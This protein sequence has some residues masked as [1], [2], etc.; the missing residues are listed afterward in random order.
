MV[1]KKLYVVRSS[2]L[3]TLGSIIVS[4][5]SKL[6]IMN[7]AYKFVT[8][9]E[10]KILSWTLILTNIILILH[11]KIHVIQQYSLIRTS[12]LYDELKCMQN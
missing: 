6:S 1:K 5:T 9:H 7:T 12:K 10:E 2:L 8:F 11:S 4:G 3:S